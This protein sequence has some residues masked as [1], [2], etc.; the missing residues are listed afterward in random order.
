MWHQYI[1]E[2]WGLRRPEDVEIPLHNSEFSVILNRSF[3]WFRE[4]LAK[5]VMVQYCQAAILQ[6]L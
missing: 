5:T 1:R 2:E 3:Q 4:F 6:Q